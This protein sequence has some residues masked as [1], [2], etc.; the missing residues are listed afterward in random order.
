MKLERIDHFTIRTHDLEA[1]RAFYEAA[2]G[3][4]IGWRPSFPFPGYWL[5]N[6]TDSMIHIAAMSATEQ[7]G[8]ANGGDGLIDYLGTRDGKGSGALD[9]IAIRASNA[10]A[11][12]R[13]LEAASVPYRERIVPDLKEWQIFVVDPN[14]VTIELIFSSSEVPL[15]AARAA[16][17][18]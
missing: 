1:T 17:R 3:L 7:L 12:L 18:G 9:H 6:G 8:V 16:G 11:Y 13:R 5:Y 4:S 15:G 14:D 10:L 2:L